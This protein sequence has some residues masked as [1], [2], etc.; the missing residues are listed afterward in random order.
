MFKNV[1]GGSI[2][3]LILIALSAWVLT[4]SQIPLGIDLQGGTEFL[5][6][7]DLSEVPLESLGDRSDRNFAQDA[8]EVIATRIDA[9]G[10]KEISVSVVGDRSILV[11]VPGKSEEDV[12]A[13]RKMIQ[14]AGQLSFHLL[15]D[16]QSPAA[17]AAAEAARAEYIKAVALFNSGQL[18]TAP[19]APERLVI[20]DKE[21]VGAPQP[22]VPRKHLVD[23]RDGF[24]VSG[25]Y[26]K[27]A[28]ASTGEDGF[29]V[30]AFEFTGVGRS[31]FSDLTG[32]NVGKSLAINL[33]GEAWSVATIQQR[34]AG[35]GQ[36]TGRYD[37]EEMRGI[38]T[39][40]NAG[41][42]PAQ[43]VLEHQQTIGP[44]LGRDSI[45]RGV[46]SMVVGVLLVVLFMAFYYL[47]AGVVADLCMFLNLLLLITCLVVFRNTLT[48]PGLA[49]LLLTI[50][51]TVD[52]N[53]LIFERI[54]EERKR[55][56]SLNQAM[57]LGFQR[58]FWTIFDAN[59]TTLITAYILFQFGSGPVKGFAVVL[60]IGLIASFFTAI[61]VSRLVLSILIKAGLVKD[62][63]M[64]E[65]M[66]ESSYDFLKHQKPV[67]TASA[68]LIGLGLLVTAIRGSDALGLDFTGGSRLLVN[69]S[70][71]ANEDQIRGLITGIKAEDGTPLF[72]DVQVQ[73]V[74]DEGAGAGHA[75]YSIRTR[76]TDLKR[77]A[78]EGDGDGSVLSG[79][80]AFQVEVEKALASA[81]LMPPPAFSDAKIEDDGSVTVAIHLRKPAGVDIGLKQVETA[82]AAGEP[83]FVFTSVTERQDDGMG[84]HESFWI[85][86]P[87]PA[88]AA[89]AS[90]PLLDPIS[91]VQAG[92][93][94]ALRG[95]DI[96]LAEAFPQV[97]SI[98]SR[99][100][101]DLQGKIFVAIMIAFGAIVFYVSLRFQL[102]FGLAAIF[103]T[104]HDILFTIGILVIADLVFGSFL[105]LKISLA[106]MAALLTVVGYSLNDTIII[107]DRIRENL[108]GT[109]RDVNYA[110]LVNL[111]VNQTLPRTLLTSLTT[112]FVVL[113]LLVF[114]GEPL[115]GF[116]FALS[117]GII[118]GTLSSIYVA[119]P[120]LIFLHKRG[121]A[122]RLALLSEAA[123][124]SKA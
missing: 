45:N 74:G 9:Y 7:V 24:K 122:R 28:F 20:T 91:K 92:I 103:A 44:A 66:G 30:I 71:S 19:A 57:T 48:F 109:K 29:P 94:L 90:G 56:R 106:V 50:G 107:F 8:K 35:R 83:P 67:L 55:G 97:D 26:L 114:G 34:I 37:A 42:L 118:V 76:T 32:N 52:A 38:V 64:K 99:V 41:S 70:Q 47:A 61:Y 15:V 77:T 27:E 87:V 62:L 22:F 80:E 43:L 60:S 4:R 23:N 69:L 63:K 89:D 5:F 6:N 85:K 33:D 86:A 59:L 104:L 49:G 119:G 101:Q 124:A 81:N 93:R 3:V 17:I 111:S 13:V 53:I 73:A 14:D 112:L 11:E 25:K 82:L 72:T 79:A 16:D 108:E 75:T 54:R 1:L 121:E 78:V 88:D 120:A 68:I 105:S 100:A 115:Q 39:V 51:M 84:L 46:Q 40:L 36:L 31:L 21:P 12:R 98:G 18:A 123:A 10:L 113:V 95:Q 110:E 2:F 102:K 116:A 65:L 117:V 96:A 58:A